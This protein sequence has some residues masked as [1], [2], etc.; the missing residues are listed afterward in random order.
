MPERLALL[1]GARGLAQQELLDARDH[2]C[3]EV[4]RKGQQLGVGQRL[5]GRG[6]EAHPDGD[7]PEQRGR[8]AST[9]TECPMLLDRG[10]RVERRPKPPTGNPNRDPNRG[11]RLRLGLRPRRRCRE[12]QITPF[13]SFLLFRD[14]DEG[15][16][17]RLMEDFEE[18]L[19]LALLAADGSA[20]IAA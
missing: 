16:L 13:A 9:H 11:L 3:G 12:T 19:L 20:W 8:C 17:D 15:K 14:V 7:E 2:L 4:A 1:Y 18:R 6:G 5:L 10:E